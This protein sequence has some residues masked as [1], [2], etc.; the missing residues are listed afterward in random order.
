MIHGFHHSSFSIVLAGCLIGCSPPTEKSESSTDTS[1]RP[2]NKS[3]DVSG[4][5][6]NKS[7][8]KRRAKRPVKRKT[9]EIQLLVQVQIQGIENGVLLQS[10]ER[11]G[12]FT[13]STGTEFLKRL[14]KPLKD[15]FGEL[16]PA[17]L[18]G[19]TDH[20]DHPYNYQWPNTKIPNA[21]KPAIWSNGPNGK[22]ENGKG[23]DITNWDDEEEE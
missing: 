19:H 22:N 6:V 8:V 11:G 10:L 5:P 14:A 13:K 4:I 9:T 7:V 2:V 15:E 21:K 17:W 16:E 12:V 18:D 20:W 1:V 3:A 23:D